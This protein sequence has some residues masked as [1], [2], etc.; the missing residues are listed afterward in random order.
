MTV[1]FLSRRRLLQPLLG[2]AVALGALATPVAAAHPDPRVVVVVGPVGDLTTTYR[3]IGRAA[4]EEAAKWTSDVVTIFSPDATWP[5]VRRGL[6]GASIVVY[7]GHGNGF[8]SPHRSAPY[9]PSQNGLGLNPVA[10]GDDAAHQY[11]GESFLAA[12]VR[13]APHAVVLLS[14]LCYASGNSESGMPD[15]SLAVAGQRVDNYAA[16]WLRAGADAVIADTFGAPG[17]YLRPILSSTS[18]IDRIWRSAPSFRGNVSAFPSARTPGAVA[19]LDPTAPDSGFNRSLVWR[20]GLRADQVVAGRADA[21]PLPMPN[22]IITPP[23]PSPPL[24][25]A[26]L[27]ASVR[28]PTLA[29]APAVRGLVAG[30]RAMLTLPVRT[31][32]GIRLPAGLELG[33]RWQA[34]ALDSATSAIP[35]ATGSSGPATGPPSPAVPPDVPPPIAL[36]VPEAPES[37]VTPVPARASRGRLSVVLRLPAVPGRYRLVTT[38]HG[39]DGVAFDAASQAL[40]PALSVKVSATLSVAYAT[41]AS[42]ATTSGSTSTFPVRIANDG[43]RP[44]A[45]PQFDGGSVFDPPAVH[46]PGPRLVATWIALGAIGAQPAAP[47]GAQGG[48]GAATGAGAQGFDPIVASVPRLAPGDQAQVDLALLAP[49]TPGQYLLVIDLVTPLDGSLAATGVAP[50]IVR[51]V[52]AAPVSEVPPRPSPF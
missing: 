42:L 23:E 6:Q 12:D 11:F 13:L 40:I 26:L 15:P 31:P 49:P 10:G 46:R 18:T 24:S 22:G 52:V 14:H 32:A 30:T 34:V 17:S 25:L 41:P 36:V 7:L 5:A 16:G 50:A 21:S 51:V 35:G 1:P 20:P 47:D 28:A 43:V 33:I 45:A 8:P 48:A 2:A 38:I 19:L 37:V 9:P 39:A 29:S 44:W 27:G 3:S 4:A